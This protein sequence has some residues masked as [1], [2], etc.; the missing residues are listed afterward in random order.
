MKRHHENAEPETSLKIQ[1]S[2]LNDVKDAV[3]WGT[4]HWV[5]YLGTGFCL[6]SESIEVNLLAFIPTAA[7]E[8]WNLSVMVA[9]S[10]ASAVFVGEI[11]GCTVFGIF[12]DKFGRK[13]AFIF[14]IVLIA[15]FGVLSSFSANI[16]HL[17]FLRF[18]VGC[19]IGGF[20]VPYDLLAELCPSRIRGPIMMSI[21]IWFALGSIFITISAYLFLDSRGWRYLTLIASIPPLASL[22]FM[23]FLDE[24]PSWL[25]AKGKKQE[26]HAIITKI[27]KRNKTKLE[28]F[29]LQ[30]EKNHDATICDLFNS[31]Y[32]RATVAVWL[33]SFSQTF[34]YYGIILF[35]PRVLHVPESELFPYKQLILSCIGE[36][37]GDAFGV[38]MIYYFS[39]GTICTLS[40]LAFGAILPLLATPGI[41]FQTGLAFFARG[42]GTIPGS[43]SWLLSSEAYPVEI[44]ATGHSYGNMMARIGAFASVYWGRAELPMIT[45]AYGFSFVAIIGAFGGW[46]NP[47]PVMDIKY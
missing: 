7:Q 2:T 5:L 35:L 44:R 38:L 22:L 42:I 36:V 16:Y 21:W 17:I 20:S 43:A 14:S 28:P 31:K 6:M 46:L 47:K 33:T 9:D 27:A 8:E 11:V 37:F 18:M 24:S 39:R 12:G 25:L 34:I 4:Y 32:C 41:L 45:L 3:G 13:P 15:G 26:A 10:I 1:T 19:G 29:D 40:F 23:Y 30:D